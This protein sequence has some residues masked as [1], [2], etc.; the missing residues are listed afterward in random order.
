M[1]YLSLFE[2]YQ[3]DLS[4]EDIDDI[5]DMFKDVIDDFNLEDSFISSAYDSNKYSITIRHKISQT[6]V[7][8]VE[9]LIIMND[10]IWNEYNRTEF[11]KS[12]NDLQKRL[13]IAGYLCDKTEFPSGF[14]E[15]FILII[16][17]K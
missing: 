7:K 11:D 15:Y 13:E 4:Q 9:I 14:A 8:T 2:S 16:S 5:R 1:K 10:G 3:N 6:T 12:L 17:K